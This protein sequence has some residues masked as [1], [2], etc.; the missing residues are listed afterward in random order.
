MKKIRNIIYKLYIILKDYSSGV[1]WYISYLEK[2]WKKVS[3]QKLSIIKSN[4]ITFI[5][6][7]LIMLS[8][9]NKKLFNRISRHRELSNKDC[10]IANVKRNLEEIF[11]QSPI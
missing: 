7:K 6:K 5:N 3:D 2:T 10:I 1:E 11:E 4:V 9:F 8:H